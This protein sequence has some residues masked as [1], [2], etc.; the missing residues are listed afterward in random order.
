MPFAGL[1]ASDTMR[2]KRRRRLGLVITTRW[3]GIMCAHKPLCVTALVEADK[4]GHGT[5]A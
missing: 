5:V 1:I 2:L 4:Q 3:L